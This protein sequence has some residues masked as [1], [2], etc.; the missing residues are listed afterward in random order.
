MPVHQDGSCNGLQH[1]AALLRD[2]HGAKQARPPHT[3]TARRTRTAAC[4]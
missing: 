2:T 1:Y 4:A 3:H